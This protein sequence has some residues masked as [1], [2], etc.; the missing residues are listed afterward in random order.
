MGR[1]YY[2][3]KA[4][5]SE[6]TMYTHTYIHMGGRGK[7]KNMEEKHIDMARTRKTAH[8]EKSELRIKPQTLELGECNTI[9]STTMPDLDFFPPPIE[10]V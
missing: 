9:H 4:S 3:W 7:P 6:G 1:L 2:G 10:P 5:P 8:R